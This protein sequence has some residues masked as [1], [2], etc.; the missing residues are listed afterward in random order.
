[1]LDLDSTERLKFN[2]VERVLRTKGEMD[3]ILN[4]SAKIDSFGSNFGFTLRR[5]T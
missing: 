3:F 5:D 1:M 2:A 4:R